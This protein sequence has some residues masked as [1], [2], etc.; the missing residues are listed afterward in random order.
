MSIVR[1][2][3]NDVTCF[4]K[5]FLKVENREYHNVMF[6]EQKCQVVSGNI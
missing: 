3:E 4:R 6:P 1:Y 2:F 5:E